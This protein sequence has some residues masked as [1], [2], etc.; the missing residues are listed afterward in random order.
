[1]EDTKLREPSTVTTKDEFDEFLRGELKVEQDALDL[2]WANLPGDLKVL[3]P[4][5]VAFAN[6]PRCGVVPTRCK[7]LSKTALLAA[8]KKMME[9]QYGPDWGKR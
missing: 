1:M 9:V 7:P 4:E 3:T 5:E 2:L 6:S 8:A